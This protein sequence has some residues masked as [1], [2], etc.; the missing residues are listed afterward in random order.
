MQTAPLEA[1]ATQTS[2]LPDPD[3]P[4]MIYTESVAANRGGAP[5]STFRGTETVN[6]SQPFNKH[7]NFTKPISDYSKVVEDE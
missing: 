7:T 1:G 4:I 5:A 3:I 2:V 6:P